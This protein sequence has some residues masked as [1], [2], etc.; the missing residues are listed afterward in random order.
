MYRIELTVTPAA[1]HKDGRALFRFGW[2]AD[3]GKSGH[4]SSPRLTIAVKPK[5]IAALVDSQERPKHKLVQL[6][7]R[8]EAILRQSSKSEP[9]LAKIVAKSPTFPVDS[10][11]L[12]V[13]RDISG[14][15]KQSSLFPEGCSR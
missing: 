14:R 5:R 9:S 7:L 10:D 8:M 4:G 12:L 11:R 13:P 1:L 15:R 6:V 3:G 2:S